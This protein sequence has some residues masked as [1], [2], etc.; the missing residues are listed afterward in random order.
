MINQE[1]LLRYA[2]REAKALKNALNESQRKN[3]ILKRIGKQNSVYEVMFTN[4]KSPGARNLK[5]RVS[6]NLF[7]AD[8]RRGKDSYTPL[9]LLM[10]NNN[11]KN[12]NYEI[13]EFIKSNKV[14]KLPIFR[15][16]N[17]VL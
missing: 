12:Y 16:V 6:T 9:E 17:I 2:R 4:S 8:G 7:S 15:G 13:A 11:G 5:E 1:T 14:T 3:L 10:N